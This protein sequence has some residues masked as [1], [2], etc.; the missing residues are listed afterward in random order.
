[1]Q[2]RKRKRAAKA[3]VAHARIEQAQD[4]CANKVMILMPF[5]DHMRGPFASEDA[6][7]DWLKE[8]GWSRRGVQVYDV[9]HPNCST[10]A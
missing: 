9:T 4:L 6:A 1:M 7:F 2:N 3:L 8:V 10:G 5:N